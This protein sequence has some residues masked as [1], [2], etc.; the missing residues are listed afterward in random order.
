[1]IKNALC[2]DYGCFARQLGMLCLTIEKK[3]PALAS[4]FCLTVKAPLARGLFCGA[5]G[6]Q[7]SPAH[8]GSG[9]LDK[10]TRQKSGFDAIDMNAAIEVQG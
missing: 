8:N 7:G 10:G 4:F 1:M 9:S 5:P 2:D 6:K 3:W